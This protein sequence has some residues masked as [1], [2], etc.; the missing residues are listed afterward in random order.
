MSVDRGRSEGA[1][2]R[3]ERREQPEA[4]MSGPGPYFALRKGDIGKSFPYRDS[5]VQVRVMTK[6]WP[7]YH[8]GRRE[9]VHAVGVIA[10]SYTAFE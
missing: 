4:D 3:S 5:S 7:D 8:T 6:E 1:G 9:H 2:R 10:L